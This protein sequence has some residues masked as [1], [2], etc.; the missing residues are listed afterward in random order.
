MLFWSSK[1]EFI[2]RDRESTWFIFKDPQHTAGGKADLCEDTASNLIFPSTVIWPGQAKVCPA[3][4]H[5][6]AS[7]VV[8]YSLHHKQKWSLRF[9]GHFPQTVGV[10]HTCSTCPSH[11]LKPKCVSDSILTIHAMNTLEDGE[12][13]K[14]KETVSWMIERCVVTCCYPV[15][16]QLHDR[17]I[18]S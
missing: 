7:L 10:Y 3:L 4:W 13:T 9:P 6:P 18:N 8:L 17:R 14:C 16:L 11:C 15:P 5:F 1:K 2:V 12:K